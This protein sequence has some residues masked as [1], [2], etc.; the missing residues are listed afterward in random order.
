MNIPT[1]FYLDGRLIL[2]AEMS[3]KTLENIQNGTEAPK[4]ALIAN[5]L[6][7]AHGGYISKSKS[8]FICTRRL[9][10]LG[11]IKDSEKQT[12]VIPDEKWQKF[13]I[14]LLEILS[15]KIVFYKELERLRGRMCSFL[16]VIRNMQMFIREITRALMQSKEK[17]QPFIF[18]N[19]DL[20]TELEIWNTDEIKYVNRVRPWLSDTPELV[21][22][23][24]YTDASGYPGGWFTEHDGESFS[25]YW[26]K[27]HAG[28]TIA[29]KEALAILHY[30]QNHL[31]K[32]KNKRVLMKCDN[33]AVFHCW[34]KGAREITLN[35]AITK[36]TM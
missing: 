14:N 31:H 4:N 29:T 32:L 13:R 10:F 30:I 34:E 36:I 12:L 26:D 17:D 28:L 25:Y 23:S 27:T 11:A 5:L 7:T 9:E 16:I 8:T 2:E 18:I 19:K 33:Q 20:R 22:I 21:G 24:V 35:S 3:E 1:F 15:Q 6:M